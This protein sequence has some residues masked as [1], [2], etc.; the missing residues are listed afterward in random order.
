MNKQSKSKTHEQIR[1]VTNS[2]K[3]V[4]GELCKGGWVR[5]WAKPSDMLIP[6]VPAIAR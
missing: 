2:G 3:V 6:I 4:T 1:V 5:F